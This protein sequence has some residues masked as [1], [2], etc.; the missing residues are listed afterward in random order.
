M[1]EGFM[2]GR[3][4]V[5]AIAV[6]VVVCAFV[7]A[8]LPM[9]GSA[10]PREITLHA[11]GMAFYLDGV[12]DANPTIHIAPGERVR[13]TL[14]NEDEGLDHDAA[15][16]AWHTSTPVIEGRGRASIVIQAPDA[17]GSTD[18]VCT[19]HRSMMKGTIAVSARPTGRTE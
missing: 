1:V 8:I 6:A 5:L 16:E 15:I 10:E 7:V 4:R 17:S 18:Y 19:L 3:S 13:L 14:V 12:D 9:V 11:R 2:S